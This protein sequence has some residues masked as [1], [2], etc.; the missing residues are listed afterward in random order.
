MMAEN[1]PSLDLVFEAAQKELDFQFEQINSLDTK[2]SI[3]LASAGIQA[4]GR[5]AKGRGGI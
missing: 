2:A 5:R 3:R 4:A 1:L